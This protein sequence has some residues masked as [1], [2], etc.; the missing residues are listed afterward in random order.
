MCNTPKYAKLEERTGKVY[1]VLKYWN[2]YT[3]TYFYKSQCNLIK[4]IVSAAELAKLNDLPYVNK[5]VGS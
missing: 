1:M 5:S 3:K 2:Y 4:G